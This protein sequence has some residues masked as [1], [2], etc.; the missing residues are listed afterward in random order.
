MLGRDIR[1]RGA[2]VAL[3]SEV[4]NTLTESQINS[5]GYMLLQRGRVADAVLV[6]ERNVARFPQS[7]NV[8]DSLGEAYAAAGEREKAI[9]NY[10][11]SL[12]LDAKNSN[13][14][15]WLQKLRADVR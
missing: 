2:A 4:V 1:G 10:H 8:Y 11:R 15:A 12:D 13:A 14:A 7:A 6:F 9:A 5:I 3:R